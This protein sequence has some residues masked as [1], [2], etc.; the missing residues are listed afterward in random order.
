MRG[1][2]RPGSCTSMTSTWPRQTTTVAA[3]AARRSRA[4]S[5]AALLPTT[6]AFGASAAASA[7]SASAPA[8]AA[9]TDTPLSVRARSIP[10][11]TMGSSC[12][13]STRRSMA[14]AAGTATRVCCTGMSPVGSRSDIPDRPFGPSDCPFGRVGEM[15]LGVRDDELDA[16]RHGELGGDGRATRDA[17]LDDVPALDHRLERETPI[18]VRPRK[19]A[20]GG[21]R[22]PRV[23]HWLTVAVAHHAPDAVAHGNPA[24]AVLVAHAHGVHADL[25][26]AGDRDAGD[27]RHSDHVLDRDVVAPADRGPELGLVLGPRLPDLRGDR[28]LAG[29][30]RGQAFGERCFRQPWVGQQDREDLR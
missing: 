13:M 10:T 22:D 19:Q 27:A 29:D 25:R 26:T 3:G 5:P 15:C 14:E 4:L 20:D 6:M 28:R 1:S 16:T 24:A 11:R 21:Y 23:G 8:L 30:R 7:T 12:P 9:S 18:G 2:S 17:A